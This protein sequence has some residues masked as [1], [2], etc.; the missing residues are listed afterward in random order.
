VQAERAKHRGENVDR[1]K[2]HRVHQHYPYEYRECGGRDE[3]IAVAMME[4]PFHLVVDELDQ[5][6]DEG[7][8]LVGYAGSRAA[9]HPPDEA[10]CEDAEQRRGDQRIDVNRPEPALAHHRLG[11]EAEVVL[12]VFGGGELFTCGHRLDQ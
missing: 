2:I 1:Q 5:Q 8:P 7:L 3:A 9:H 6:F 10:E 12:D 4:D 11:K